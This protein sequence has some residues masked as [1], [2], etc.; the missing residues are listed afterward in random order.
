MNNKPVSKLLLVFISLLSLI[1]GFLGGA[2]GYLYLTYPASDDLDPPSFVTGELQIHFMELGNKYSGDSILIQVGEYDILV[3]AGSKRSSYDTIKNYLDTH[4][5]DDTLEYVI[6]THAHED[7]YANFAGNGTTSLLT[8]YTITNLIQFSKTNQTTGVMYNNYLAMVDKIEQSGTKVC[9]ALESYNNENGCNRII[10]LGFDTEIE[11]LYQKF[12]ED[13]ASSENDYSVC[14]LIN[15]GSNH[16]LFTGDLEEDGEESLVEENTLPQVSLFKA[17][18]HGSSTS[19]HDVLLDVIQPEIV[20]ITAVVGNFE[21]AKNEPGNVN[22]NGTFPTTATLTRIAKHTSKVYA[23]SLG[24]ISQNQ[25]GTYEDIGFESLNGDIVV[26]SN[27][28]GITV[29]GSNN[30]TLLKDTAWAQTYRSGIV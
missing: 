9:N 11:I 30:N 27:S 10:D 17:G 1:L 19:S 29:T 22:I 2:I 5:E 23:T 12:Y 26:T 20:V 6:V 25:D 7:H 16:F 15:Q 18:H 14:F 24:L 28:S 3:D 13:K 4:L 21:Y 8:D